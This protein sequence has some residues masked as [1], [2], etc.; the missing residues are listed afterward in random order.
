MKANEV[1]VM[2]DHALDHELIAVARKLQSI[3]RRRLPTHL[4]LTQAWVLTLLADRK[5]LPVSDIATD[6]DMSLSATSN[7]LDQM[8]QHEWLTRAENPRDRRVI[9]VGLTEAGR[10]LVDEVRARRDEVWREV[11]YD[12]GE[13]DA[14]YLKRALTDL[15][16][17]LAKVEAVGKKGVPSDHP[18]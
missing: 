12:L 7:V 5:T 15:D 6:L 8:M 2:L 10:V 1:R 4:T 18:G 3:L 13:D 11:L 14:R 16:H 17:A 9:Y